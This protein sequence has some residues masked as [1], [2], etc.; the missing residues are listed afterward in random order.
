MQYILGQ[1]A[2]A[3]AGWRLWTSRSSFWL[4]RSDLHRHAGQASVGAFVRYLVDSPG[5]NYAFW[6][7]T[8]VW[9]HSEQGLLH[10]L[11]PAAALW[12]RHLSLKFGITVPQQVRVGPGLYIGHFG[13]IVVH[14]DAVIGRDCNISQGVTIGQ[15]NRGARQ[16]VPR[17]GDRVYIGPGAKLV[18]DIRIGSDAAIGANA[19]VTRDVPERGV[20]AGVPAAVISTDG[21]TGYVNRIDYPEFARRSR[22][23]EPPDV[24]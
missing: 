16:G 4:V 11:Y 24:R 3:G 1:V 22:G 19:V 5:F 8:A 10:L 14:P 13:G 7:R 2:S 12:K 23:P 9:L 18:G 20:V 17:L 6:L 21:S 15:T